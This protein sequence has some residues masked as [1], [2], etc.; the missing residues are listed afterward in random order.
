MNGI[1]DQWHAD[2]V[3]LQSLGRW[4][5]AYKYLL[6][7]IDILSKYAWVAPLK[8]KTGSELVKAFTKIF[9]QGRNQTSY[10]PMHIPN[11][12]YNKTKAQVVERFNRTLKQIMWRLFTTASSYHHLDRLNDIVNGNYNQTFHLSIK[13]KPSEVTVMN[14]QQLW[15]TIYGRRI[16][17]VNYN[18]KVGDQ[19]KISMHKRVFGK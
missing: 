3:D 18:F 16:S 13:M 1:G 15:R 7:G 12:T 19:V 14:F 11:L 5:R 10:K 9:Q 8:A 2:L 4:N 17:S 6:A